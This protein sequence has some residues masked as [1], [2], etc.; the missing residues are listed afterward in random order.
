MYTCAKANH[1]GTLPLTESTIGEEA[2]V[3]KDRY[4]HIDT[5]QGQ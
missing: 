1:T 2:E 4:K 3:F 5:L